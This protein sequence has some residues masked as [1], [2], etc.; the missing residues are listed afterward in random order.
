MKNSDQKFWTARYKQ[1]L[2]GWDVGYPTTPIT[3]FID[4]LEDKNLRI[5]IP[6]AGNAY[7]AEYL[8]EKGFKHTHILDIAA[9]PIQQFLDRNPSF[10]K[11]Q[12]IQGDFFAHQGEY[13]LIF[14]QTFFCSFPPHAETRRAYAEKMS[15]LLSESGSLIGVWFNFPL[16]SDMERRPFGGSKEEYLS[17]F[18]PHF[19]TCYMEACYN[20]I[21]PRQGSELFGIMKK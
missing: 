7:E 10:P 11:G 15:E 3:N 14:E 18:Q 17:Y 1:Q 5:L 20:S 8:W 9:F 2:T 12:A 16:T 21:P 4:Q 13:D 6:G 19:Q